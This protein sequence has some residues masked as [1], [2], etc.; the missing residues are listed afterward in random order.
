MHMS[1]CMGATSQ[2]AVVLHSVSAL[3]SGPCKGVGK[4]PGSG[5]FPL[6]GET[7]EKRDPSRF[8]AS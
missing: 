6:P 3:E 8:P 7:K 5:G 1:Y 4:G 2:R